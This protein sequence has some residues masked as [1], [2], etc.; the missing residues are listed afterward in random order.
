[1][2]Q[3]QYANNK[4]EPDLALV[5]MTIMVIHMKVVG[6]N[7]FIVQIALQIKLVLGINV[8]IRA[9]V[10]VVLMLFVQLLVMYR[11]VTVYPVILEILSHTA[12]LNH[13]VRFHIFLFY[14][15]LIKNYSKI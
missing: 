1:V 10:Y 6:Q 3:M 11:L 9:Q 4:M 8:L 2:E 5:L 15:N 13:Q 7:V 12:N 14:I